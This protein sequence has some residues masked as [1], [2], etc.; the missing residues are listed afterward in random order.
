MRTV[1]ILSRKGGSGKSTLSYF[2]AHGMAHGVA[3]KIGSD[4]W[5]VL[6]R[7]DNR[8][9]RPSDINSKRRYM[10]SSVPGDE[11][12]KE[13]IERVVRMTS[14]IPESFLVMDGGANRRNYDYAACAIADIVLIPVGCSEE[15][16]ETADADYE[17][18]LKFIA[19]HERQTEIY[20]VRNKWP[21]V[22]R[23]YDSLMTKPWIQ[24]YIPRWEEQGILF[25]HI[26]PDMPSLMDL[27]N[28]EDP[29]ATLLLQKLSAGFAEVIATRIEY[30]PM[31]RY[32]NGDS[33]GDGHTTVATPIL[34]AAE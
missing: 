30:P 15:D 10:V 17:D 14:E 27:A 20:F 13:H 2:L 12:D 21:G 16:L 28:P 25:P 24:R 19:T 1:A 6:L 9:R 11:T 3:D 4:V 34:E 22:Q 32:L 33:K 5:T 8:T 7:T 23:K 18:F 26:I 29:Q 31:I